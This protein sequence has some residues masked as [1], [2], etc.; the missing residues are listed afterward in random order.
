MNRLYILITIIG[1]LSLSCT[2]N[3]PG[4]EGIQGAQGQDGLNG[5]NGTESFVFEYE[6]SFTAPEYSQLVSLPSDF[7][8]LDSDIMLVF[9]LW[10]V[11]DDGLEVWRS[12][13]QTLY[14]ENGIL[15]YNYDFTKYDANIFL[16]GTVNLN[17]LGAGH[18][19]NW[20]ARIVVVPGQF[21]NGRTSVDYTDYNQVKEMFDLSPSSLATENYPVRP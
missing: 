11:T 20:I 12:L 6:F 16:D 8:M 3:L 10:D 2:Q 14:F 17:S 7:N 5:T 21:A 1:L 19:D 13:P 4:P 18:T 15:N 9:F